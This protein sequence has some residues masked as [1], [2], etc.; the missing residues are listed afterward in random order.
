MSIKQIKISSKMI[1]FLT[2]PK[3]QNFFLLKLFKRCASFYTHYKFV[4]T[5]SGMQIK[6]VQNLLFSMNDKAS[7]FLSSQVEQVD[8]LVI[9]N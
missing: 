1:F 8:Q 3:Q 9:L 6:K 5:M 7:K 2:M 4:M